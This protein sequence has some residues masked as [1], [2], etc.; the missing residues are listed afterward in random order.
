MNGYVALT[1]YLLSHQWREVAI[2]ESAST[3]TKGNALV[4]V[5]YA[6]EPDTL[7][8]EQALVGV[9]CVT[10]E[11]LWSLERA[12]SEASVN[13]PSPGAPTPRVELDLHL[14]GPSVHHNE[15]DAYLLGQFLTGVAD[16]VN[17]LVM[18][19]FGRNR[20]FRHLQTA[21]SGQPDSV[22]VRFRE[23]E[24]LVEEVSLVDSTS[25]SPLGHGIFNL[26]QIMG[27][28]ERAAQQP[29]QSMLNAHLTPA[30]SA[31]RALGKL[32]DVVL[33]AGWNV[34]GHLMRPGEDPTP[35]SWSLAGAYRLS[36]ATQDSAQRVKTISACGHVDAWTWPT[37][38]IRFLTDDGHPIR[39][40]VPLAQQPYV[41]HL[42]AG[43]RVAARFGV[44]EHRGPKG[45]LIGQE[46][47]LIDI[48]RDERLTPA[49][50]AGQV[51]ATAEL[52]PV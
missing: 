15:T 31:R 7:A 28:A 4:V 50:S 24:L 35:I 32:A 23:P 10:H 36:R 14:F 21:G 5:P 12:I 9:A 40:A 51:A 3:W 1:S 20:V 43:V 47:V 52:Q 29:A 48:T 44:L 49:V 37:A 41:E 18:N 8:W 25:A 11:P 33:Q 38:E 30:P 45:D 19:A 17:E 27:A 39:A 26:V 42:E 2:L 6:I 22:Q 16:T 46:H 34:H 13:V